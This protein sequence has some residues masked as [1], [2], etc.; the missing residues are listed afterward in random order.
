MNTAREGRSGSL[1]KWKSALELVSTI[2]I[3]VVAAS[4]L[5]RL[6]GTPR[7][8]PAAPRSAA[9]AA[10]PLP[11]EPM[12]ISDAAIRGDRNAKVAMIEFSDFQ[13][14]FCSKFVT[15]T[16]VELQKN[17]IDNGKVLLA[18]RNFP[19]ETLHPFARKAAETAECAHRQSKFWEM[20]DQ[21]FAH[22][23]DLAPEQ[24]RGYAKNVGLDLPT[25]DRCLS[26]EVANQLKADASY[27]ALGAV[28][29]TPTFLL[30]TV[31][32]DGRVRVTKQLFGA[33]P[34]QS[35]AT[36]LDELL[37]GKR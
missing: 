11:A 18:F 36:P 20:H 21:L 3:V 16:W 19:L 12:P 29:G 9:K 28:S 30:G 31:E 32:S 6:W 22:P 5:W 24:L 1:D 27:A 14:P 7:L 13:C 15:T 4:L 25:F 33:L 35:F 2:L 26:G 34:I 37:A 8:A 10:P 23:K 17:Y